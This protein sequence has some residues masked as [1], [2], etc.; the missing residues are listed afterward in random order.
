MCDEAVNIYHSTIQ[1][2]P[3]CYK[4]QEMCDKGVNKCFPAFVYI[5]D[6]YKTQ[7]ICD[8]AIYENPLILVYCPDKCKPQRMFDEAVNDCLAALKFIL[9]WFVTSKMIKK[10]L[11]SLYADDSILYFNE[12]SGNLVISCNEMGTLNIN[13]YNIN[14]DDTN[15]NEDDPATIIHIRRLT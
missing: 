3:D 12:D 7:G 13:L 9:D 8:R 11:T 5:F 4:T 10:L 6:Q 15:Y 14:F 2:I 1:F